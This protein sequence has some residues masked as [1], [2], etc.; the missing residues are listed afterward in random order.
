MKEGTWKGEFTEGSKL[1]SVKEGGQTEV[2][3]KI[4]E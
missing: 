4:M 3:N 2:G 1:G